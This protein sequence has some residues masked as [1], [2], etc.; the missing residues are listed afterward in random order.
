M[1]QILFEC[2]KAAGREEMKQELSSSLR[3]SEKY[4]FVL[5]PFAAVMDAELHANSAKGDRPGWLSMSREVALL[6]IYWHTAKL[7][8]AV[9]NNDAALIREH[10]ADVANMAMM[11]LDVCDGL[12]SAAPTQPAPN[13]CAQC[14]KEYRHA[15]TTEGCPKCAPGVRV[16]EA[17]FRQPITQPTQAEQPTCGNTPYDEGP[18]TVAQVSQ[19]KAGWVLIATDAYEGGFGKGLQAAETG[20]EIANPWGDEP[21]REAW[22]LGCA[23]GKERYQPKAAQQEPVLFVSPGQLEKHADPDDNESGRYLP[24][25][26]TPAGNFTQPLYAADP[27]FLEESNRLTLYGAHTEGLS[28]VDDG[29]HVLVWGGAFDDSTWESPD[30]CLPDWWFLNGSEFEVTANPTHWMPLPPTDAAISKE[31]A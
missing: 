28:H 21:G 26:K 7:S 9:K 16:S 6:E 3:V 4:R 22:S 29:P 12:L 23:M 2:G 24:A 19:P 20:K 1:D 11:L 14:K 13:K 30:A 15:A 8:A 10:C 17:E 31:Q 25:R 18:F 5:E 27:Y